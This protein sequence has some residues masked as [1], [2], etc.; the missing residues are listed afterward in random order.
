[1]AYVR[2]L[3]GSDFTLTVK[4]EMGIGKSVTVGASEIDLLHGDIDF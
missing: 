3:V 4:K 2:L 1:M